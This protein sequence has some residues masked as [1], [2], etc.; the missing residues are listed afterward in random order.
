MSEHDVMV[1]VQNTLSPP[2][3]ALLP[4]IEA[5]FPD[6]K[7]QLRNLLAYSM[8]K[9]GLYFGKNDKIWLLKL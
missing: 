8:R 7:G 9:D 6:L 5:E 3:A 4:I 2:L 1:M